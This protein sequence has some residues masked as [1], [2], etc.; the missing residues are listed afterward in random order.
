M[1][2][3]WKFQ[4]QKDVVIVAIDEFDKA[5]K[6]AVE[7]LGRQPARDHQ[8]LQVPAGGVFVGRVV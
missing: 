7:Y 6:V 3:G 2:D 1:A 4:A 5:R 8:F